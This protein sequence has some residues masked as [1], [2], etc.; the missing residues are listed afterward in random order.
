MDEFITIK[1]QALLNK[2]LSSFIA[3][4]FISTSI[5]P[6]GWAQAQIT[7]HTVLNLPVPGSFVPPTD[8]FVPAIIKGITIHPDNALLF[9]F[10]IDLGDSDLQGQEIKPEADT[11]IKYFLAA[12]TVPEKEMWVNLSPYEADRVIPEGLGDT[13]MGRDLLAQDYLLKQLT[14]S[15]MYPEDELG[16]EFW[17]R[18]HERAYEEFGVTDVPVNTFNKVWIVPEKAVVYEHEKSRS[19]YVLES[20]LKVMLEEDYVAAQ[21]SDAS[22]VTRDSKK[23]SD[24]ERTTS[25]A[26]LATSLI[27]EILIPE[28]ERE[29]NEGATFAKLRQIY[30]S[31]IL[32]TWYKQNL[33][34][35]LLG[36]VYVD[37]N[38]TRGVDT[39]DKQVTNKIYN[40][41]L[42]AFEKGVYDYIRE[43]YD[44]A[45][46]EIVPRKY[47]SGGVNA[48]DIAMIVNLQK[49][50][51]TGQLL[52]GN[53]V[54]KDQLPYFLYGDTKNEVVARAMVLSQRGNDDIEAKVAKI[55]TEIILPGQERQA[56]SRMSEFSIAKLA[57]LRDAAMI[58]EEKVIKDYVESLKSENSVQYNNGL[59]FIFILQKF[60]KKI[61]FKRKFGDKLSIKEILNEKIEDLVRD[62]M[63][64]ELILEKEFMYKFGFIIM[65]LKSELMDSKNVGL[66][67]ELKVDFTKILGKVRQEIQVVNDLSDHKMSEFVDNFFSE[68]SSVASGRFTRSGSTVVE[69]VVAEI[70]K[71]LKHTVSSWGE[72]FNIVL[73]DLEYWNISLS[74][75]EKKEKNMTKVYLQNVLFFEVPDDRQE[76]VIFYRENIYRYWKAV[77][78]D[79]IAKSWGIQNYSLL[80]MQVR[81]VIKEIAQRVNTLSEEKKQGYQDGIMKIYEQEKEQKSFPI[82]NP[83]EVYQVLNEFLNG[84]ILDNKEINFSKNPQYLLK[85]IQTI[86]DILKERLSHLAGGEFIESVTENYVVLKAIKFDVKSFIGDVLPEKRREHMGWLVETF[87]NTNLIFAEFF[88]EFDLKPVA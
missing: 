55:K 51:G 33:R 65:N 43:D 42:E 49:I 25:D 4:I 45:T 70:I 2:V 86:R 12:L 1:H 40:Q 47:F 26:S 19:A 8:G 52:N 53:S 29:V 32:A 80:T 44:P 21:H 35:T 66:R 67:D 41:Y 87:K 46:Q 14:A 7:P 3:V 85:A 61:N 72:E 28:I 75:D 38:K 58:N 84:Q 34:E 10:I 27:R 18:V 23:Q 81:G 36:Q 82:L 88:S 9:D 15:L 56:K 69:G 78:L 17:D 22:L 76:D 37:Q 83:W 24:M 6:P 5:I 62:Y 77:V 59:K 64:T 57:G 30:H 63:K 50:S 79:Q 71:E 74:L 48:G 54:S 73:S 31:M 20:H 16:E 68:G 39:D 60:E 11:L 13:E